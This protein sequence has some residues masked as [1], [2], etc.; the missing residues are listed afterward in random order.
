MSILT[1]QP[2][3]YTENAQFSMFFSTVVV[4]GMSEC[5]MRP[6]S[7]AHRGQN[8]DSYS[9][10]V[11]LWF[12]TPC[13]I[14]YSRTFHVTLKLTSKLVVTFNFR[15]D[16]VSA[17]TNISY[18]WHT[19]TFVPEHIYSIEADLHDIGHHVPCMTWPVWPGHRPPITPAAVILL[20]HDNQWQ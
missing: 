14:Y 2:C 5:W 11:S 7:A 10:S 12:M 9:S 20:S 15:P 3:F 1:L 6:P 8:P 19:V 13:D 18:W 17:G 16:Q 4:D